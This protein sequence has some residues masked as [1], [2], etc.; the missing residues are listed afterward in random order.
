MNRVTKRTWI[1][2]LFLLVLVAGMVFFLWEYATKAGDWVTFQG[3]PHI[4]NSGNIGCGTIV[5]RSGNVLLDIT[6]RTKRP[7]G[8]PCTGWVTGR[9]LSVQARFPTTVRKWRASTW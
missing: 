8:P 7:G 1:M 2:A 3:S 5:D 6:H 9:D 4:Y